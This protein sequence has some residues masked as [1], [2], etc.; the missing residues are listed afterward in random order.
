MKLNLISFVLLLLISSCDR[1][2]YTEPDPMPHYRP[3]DCS[4]FD[5]QWISDWMPYELNNTYK[6][7][8]SNGKQFTLTVDS[9]YYSE[10]YTADPSGLCHI[11]GGIYAHAD[12]NIPMDINM[13][14]YINSYQK[15]PGSPH[16]SLEWMDGIVKFKKFAGR[17][18][19][20]NDETELDKSFVVKDKMSFGSKEYNV[21]NEIHVNSDKL[22]KLYLV[23]HHGVVAFTTADSTIFWL[24]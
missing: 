15:D 19:T 1:E 9:Q 10:E 23:K 8:D 14:F 20:L 17:F 11:H 16:L 21:V 2:Y 4:A 3:N 24:K 7:V 5:P 13:R 22:Q 6:Y 12:D 18:E